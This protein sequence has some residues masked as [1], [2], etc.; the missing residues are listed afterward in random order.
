MENQIL[1]TEKMIF[2]GNCIAKIEKGEN[3]GKT[4]L[5]SGAL[6]HELVEVKFL[7]STKDYEIAEE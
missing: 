2:G 6:P 1:K 4:V 5:I 3:K 7:N